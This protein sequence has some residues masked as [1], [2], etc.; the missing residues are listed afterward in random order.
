VKK[1]TSIVGVI[2]LLVFVFG[3]IVFES[4]NIQNFIFYKSGLTPKDV[5]SLNDKI[6]LSSPTDPLVKRTPILTEIDNFIA[7]SVKGSGFSTKAYGLVRIRLDAVLTEIPKT[8]VPKGKV[9]IW[10]IYN[11][12]V[13]AKS[14]D[15]T[16]AFDLAGNYVYPKLSDFTKY[17]DI[18]VITH[19]HNDH[20]NAA[21]VKEALKNGVTVIIP[22]D[23]MTLKDNEF[24]RDPNGL[25]ALDL[26]R[27]QYGINSDNLISLKPL[28][29][30]TVK[31]V[32]ITAY[33]GNHVG[34]GSDLEK[35][36]YPLNWY[37]VDLSGITLLHA[38]DGMSFDYRPDFIDKKVDVFIPH[39]TTIDPMTNDT[40]T[41][42]VPNPKIILPLHVLEL[43]HGPVIVDGSTGTNMNYQNILDNYSNGFYRGSGKTIF[44]PLIWGE[45]FEL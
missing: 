33:P 40:F 9:K 25:P 3:I 10:Y 30:T 45:S 39:A 28:Q 18:L 26:I 34:P 8:V 31:G 6:N 16:V 19:F 35:T 42:L 14:L 7:G 2:L 12:G 4:A 23:T 41:K 44:M 32:D 37:Y 11:M 1:I 22:G 15:K 27:K 38:G 21:L 13:I 5:F 17:I 29:K 24:V 43:G 20:F 36:P